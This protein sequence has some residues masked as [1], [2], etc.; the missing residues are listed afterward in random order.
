RAGD[1][2][3]EP[4]TG[5]PDEHFVH[6]GF[7]F[8][9]GG[10]SY[11]PY[12]GWPGPFHDKFVG[13]GRGGVHHLAALSREGSGE[14][15]ASEHSQADVVVIA[16]HVPLKRHRATRLDHGR[17]SPETPDRGRLPNAI[18]DHRL[19]G[20]E[21]AHGDEATVVGEVG[22]TRSKRCAGEENG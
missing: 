19:A 7:G 11:G 15:G 20:L 22:R 13:G 10:D 12:D 21:V 6:H 3:A 8:R 14:L 17:V 4:F 9:R 1:D 5:D 16:G 18:Y 2:Y